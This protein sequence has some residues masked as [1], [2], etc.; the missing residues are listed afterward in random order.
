MALYESENKSNLLDYYYSNSLSNIDEMRNILSPYLSPI[1]YFRCQL[2][3]QWPSG[4]KLESFHGKK[5]F[6]GLS[7]VVEPEVTFLAHHDIVE[8]DVPN[9]YSAKSI[10][11]QLAANVHIQVPDIGGELLLWH[12]DITANDFDSIRGDSYGIPPNNLGDPDIVVKPK[13]GQLIIFN[14][15]KMHSVSAGKNKSRV[16]LSCFIGYRGEHQP[17]TYWS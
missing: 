14:S 5:M 9:N 4:A 17:L 10:Q 12:K 11:M 13:A 3:E 1:D 6:V 8:K 16:S 2:D 15:R 7:R